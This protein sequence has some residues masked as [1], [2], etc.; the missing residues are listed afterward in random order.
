MLV[1]GLVAAWALE[2]LAVT[3]VVEGVDVVV[4]GRYTSTG[5]KGRTD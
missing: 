1:I 2:V 5:S 3:L 4:A